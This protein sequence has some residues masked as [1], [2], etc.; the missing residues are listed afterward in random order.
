MIMG[1][2][3]YE[4]GTGGRERDNTEIIIKLKKKTNRNIFCFVF[5]VLVRKKREV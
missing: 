1:L 3:V 4:E 5:S 2:C